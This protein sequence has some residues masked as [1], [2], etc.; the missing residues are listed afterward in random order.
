[1]PTFAHD[2]RERQRIEAGMESAP[3][4]GAGGSPIAVAL[5]LAAVAGQL[6]A[7]VYLNHGHVFATA[8]TGNTVLLGVAAL[9][10]D[11]NNMLY[12]AAPILAFVAGVLVARWA[13][14]RSRARAHTLALVFE[15]LTVT[16]AGLLPSGFPATTLV[17][18]IAFVSAVQVESFRRIG[19]FSYSSTYVSGDLREIAEGL[20][21]IFTPEADPVAR[22][23]ARLKFRD[24][25]LVWLCFLAGAVCG[26]LAA[27]RLGNHGFWLAL[28]LLGVALALQLSR[29]RSF[30]SPPEEAPP[31]QRM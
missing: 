2:T 7:L 21:Q 28:P 9:S 25:G 1:M 18:G 30:A 24:L 29:T 16:V 5:L 8:M 27:A 31:V 15:L 11:A 12:H 22:R 10:H 19:P 14:P 6:D 17:A 13:A 4:P 3:Q 23:T 20:A 26:A